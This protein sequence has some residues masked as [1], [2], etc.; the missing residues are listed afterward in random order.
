MGRGRA[1]QAGLGIVVLC[2]YERDSVVADDACC[3]DADSPIVAGWPGWMETQRQIRGGIGQ[4][5]TMADLIA[6]KRGLAGQLA[7]C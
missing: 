2:V 7:V 6:L 5:R 1:T 4:Y 3:G